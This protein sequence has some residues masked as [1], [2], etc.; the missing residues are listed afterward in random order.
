MIS[1]VDITNFRAIERA[2]IA[3]T[4]LNVFTGPNGAG[5][6]S[7]KSA[8]EY[9][10]TRRNEWTDGRGTGLDTQVRHGAKKGRV[11]I[12]IDNQQIE[13]ECPPEK[14]AMQQAKQ[15]Y[16]AI[17]LRNDSA[18]SERMVQAQLRACELLDQPAAD[19]KATLCR[20][21]RAELDADNI[22]LVNEL[23]PRWH[24]MSHWL[25]EM[26]LTRGYRGAI[27]AE[28]LLKFCTTER[29][30]AKRARD[31]QQRKVERLE[32]LV[33]SGRPSGSP[34]KA[35]AARER[36]EDV[37]REMA[38]LAAGRT[39]AIELHHAQQ[40][41]WTARRQAREI[42]E[43]A[44]HRAEVDLQEAQAKLSR[45]TAPQ[46]DAEQLQ[47]FRVQTDA[48]IA[49]LSAILDDTFHMDEQP[50]KRGQC[51]VREML[52]HRTQQAEV[53]EE[54]RAAR[55]ERDDL[56]VALEAASAWRIVSARVAEAEEH[57]VA[58]RSQL[59]LTPEVGEPP[60][61]P[62]TEAD[63][64]RAELEAA[65]AVAREQVEIADAMAHQALLYEEH[66]EE[67]EHAREGLD[68]L[69]D[70]VERWEGLCRAFDTRAV[71]SLPSLLLAE[72][73]DPFVADVDEACRE[74]FGFGVCIDLDPWGIR[75]VTETGDVPQEQASGG[76]R[77]AMS[78]VV[79]VELARRTGLRL[80]MID[81]AQRLDA[82]RRPMLA[83]YLL[84]SEVQALVFLAA[85]EKVIE[86]GRVHMLRPTPPDD[87]RTAFWWVEGGRLERLSAARPVP[88]LGTE[89]KHD[90]W[91]HRFD[92]LRECV[93]C[94]M[95]DRPV[96]V[97]D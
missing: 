1:S 64:R 20:A 86:S 15:F 96:G 12:T 18:M 76:E 2:T 66:L 38:E 60:V 48:E 27:S 3:L 8:I 69:Q 4:S 75:I 67:L 79:Q 49:R 33:G 80:V 70:E 26:T 52:S 92:G 82:E 30:G 91:Q 95:V 72:R 9:A 31:E 78:A 56:S 57:L 29:P 51:K 39:P 97:T 11:R 71:D 43:R 55:E 13:A 5:K 93:D 88:S 50:C 7:V 22:D 46:H 77:V 90:H 35:E 83:S 85:Q 10:L 62:S 23:D 16:A 36:L 37:M 74:R 34:E 17:G 41:E 68:A 42:A 14:N 89:C 47:S 6:S 73:L 58:A 19:Q 53:H 63:P 32:A 40:R 59:D 24:D 94:G 45:M 54:L 25:D 44:V 61:A 84:A 87:P 81:E 21:L 65:L 28:G